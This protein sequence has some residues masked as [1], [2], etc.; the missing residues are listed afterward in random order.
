MRPAEGRLTWWMPRENEWR[1]RTATGKKRGNFNIFGPRERKKV[2]SKKK[3]KK[4][5]KGRFSHL[6]PLVAKRGY[7][8]GGKM[9]A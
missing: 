6:M 4:S 9:I 3:I 5:V 7:V 2:F 8:S 1:I